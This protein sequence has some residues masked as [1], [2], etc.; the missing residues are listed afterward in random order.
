MKRNGHRLNNI[1]TW[2]FGLDKTNW[3]KYEAFFDMYDSIEKLLIE[4]NS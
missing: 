2:E 1:T 4:E 3:Y